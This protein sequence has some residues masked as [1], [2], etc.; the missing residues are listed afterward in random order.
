[1]S[2]RRREKTVFYIFPIANKW[3]ILCLTDD[4]ILHSHWKKA[5]RFEFNSEFLS[6]RHDRFE[7][8]FANSEK[9]KLVFFNH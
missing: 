7:K 9:T 2:F 5:G 6:Y 8:W 3:Q 1:M 4:T